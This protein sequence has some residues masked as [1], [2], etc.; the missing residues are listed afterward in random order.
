M[1]DVI[2][3][4]EGIMPPPEP[5]SILSAGC[6]Q[7]SGGCVGR[8]RKKS[9][10]KGGLFTHRLCTFKSSYGQQAPW[11]QTPAQP[12]P[13]S[14]SSRRRA[15]SLGEQAERVKPDVARLVLQRVVKNLTCSRVGEEGAEAEE[16]RRC[17]E[18]DSEVWE[19]RQ[20]PL[21]SSLGPPPPV[22]RYEE[23]RERASERL[24]TSKLGLGFPKDRFDD[25]SP[26]RA[27]WGVQGPGQQL[28]EKERVERRGRE[29]ERRRDPVG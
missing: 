5:P 19:L 25:P 9:S 20:G 23:G 8:R 13:R 24:W 4:N 16:Q 3:D 6:A 27:H 21:G 26:K 12:C 17:K 15:L 18:A 1:P 11:S 28:R 2:V 10:S 14:Q 7:T 29:E 22:G